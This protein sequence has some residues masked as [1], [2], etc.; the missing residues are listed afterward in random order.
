MFFFFFKFPFMP[1]RVR[2]IWWRCLSSN[3]RW[4]DG[5]RSGKRR[6]ENELKMP[7]FLLNIRTYIIKMLRTFTRENRVWIDSMWHTRMCP[8]RESSKKKKSTVCCISIHNIVRVT[9]YNIYDI[10]VR[11]GH[12]FL[13]MVGMC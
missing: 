10:V 9:Q 8:A 3:S 11:I 7:F 4:E 5:R 1:L 2:T 6:N 13:G 12:G